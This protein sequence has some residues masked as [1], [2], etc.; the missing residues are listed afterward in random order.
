MKLKT[1]K[2]AKATRRTPQQLDAVRTA[3]MSVLKLT[4]PMTLRSLFYQLVGRYTLPKVETA[5]KNLGKM[6]CKLREAGIVP[7]EWVIDNTRTF[8][9][10][11]TFNGVGAGLRAL[12]QQYRRDPWKTQDSTVYV[13]T[14]KDGVASILEQETEPYCVPVGV[15]HGFGSHTFLHDLAVTIEDSGK[16]AHILYFGDHDPSGVAVSKAAERL[17]RKFAPHAEIHFERLAVNVDQIAEYDL[18]TRPSKK[19]DRRIKN[20]VGESVEVDAM[21]PDVIR[22]LGRD[23][24]ES[25]I[26][27]DAHR[28]TMLLESRERAQLEEIA[29]SFGSDR[30][31]DDD[32]E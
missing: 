24:I 12:A 26:D 14:E 29:E 4:H 19:S 5:Y 28:A 32:G 20:F 11:S 10:P 3:I 23:A 13:L 1:P 22:T 16:P 27:W 21:P 7:W 18:P 30:E 17:L 2:H 8:S 31:G 25:L 9:V 15:V 6:L